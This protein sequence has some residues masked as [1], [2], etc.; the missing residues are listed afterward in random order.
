MGVKPQR[1]V[2]R[3]RTLVISIAEDFQL[4][5]NALPMN[6]RGIADPDTAFDPPCAGTAFAAG[7][8]SIS[9]GRSLREPAF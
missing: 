7:K 5:A 9:S 3:V 8:C 1:A 4:E 6:R 2:R